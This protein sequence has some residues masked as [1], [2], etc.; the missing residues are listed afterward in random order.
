[1]KL[2]SLHRV[3][4]LIF[5]V[6][7]ICNGKHNYFIRGDRLVTNFKEYVISHKTLKLNSESYKN[8]NYD[9]NYFLCCK[10]FESAA[11]LSKLTNK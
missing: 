4:F 7:E 8:K 6:V 10:Y 2:E 11:L 5:V 1:M 9:F 3:F